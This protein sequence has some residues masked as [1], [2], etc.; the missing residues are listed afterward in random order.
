MLCDWPRCPKEAGVIEWCKKR[1]C[2]RHMKAIDSIDPREARR[3]LG[4]DPAVTTGFK[5]I[6]GT[7]FR[8]PRNLKEPDNAAAAAHRK[9]TRTSG[10]TD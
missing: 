9:P 5:I 7:P 3:V 6:G 1:V 2:D 4:V 10:R 8:W